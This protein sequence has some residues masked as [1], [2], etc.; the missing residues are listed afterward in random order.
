MDNYPA[1]KKKN[2]IVSCSTVCKLNC[3]GLSEP[4]DLN[5]QF[6]FKQTWKKIKTLPNPKIG[7]IFFYK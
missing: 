5:V 3:S 4:V 1:L 2:T 7:G 6:A